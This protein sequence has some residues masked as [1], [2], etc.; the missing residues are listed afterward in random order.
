M[1]TIYYVYDTI[2]RDPQIKG[3][4]TVDHTRWWAI[5]GTLIEAIAYLNNGAGW[6]QSDETWHP[7]ALLYT[8]ETNPE[9]FI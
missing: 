1:L 7:G 8:S 4:V 9:L 6:T 3:L 2:S 5:D